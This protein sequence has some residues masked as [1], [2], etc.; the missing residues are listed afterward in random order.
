MPVTMEQV[1]F[2]LLPEEPDYKAAAQLG[3]EALPLLH[4]LVQGSDPELA[5]KA[6]SLAGLIDDPGA[7][8]VL[9]AAASSEHASARVAAAHATRQLSPQL[10]APV[11]ARL[12]AD[13]DAG[14]RKV[15]INAV[16]ESATPELRQALER[17]GQND[18]H[19]PLRAMAREAA[20]R[21]GP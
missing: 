17:V 21:V 13:D 10:A 1:R 14:V 3:P 11:L 7:S 4:E 12:V 2:A 16:P 20:E 9:H 5:T 6:A 15:A 8:D 19:A 18:R